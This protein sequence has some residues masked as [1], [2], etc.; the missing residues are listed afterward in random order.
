MSPSST[1][2]RPSSGSITLESASMT[3][4]SLGE[5]ASGGGAASLSVTSGQSSQ[6]RLERLGALQDAADVRP[7]RPESWRRLQR[8]MPN[9]HRPYGNVQRSP[10]LVRTRQ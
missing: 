1:K 6:G 10:N 9:T 2:S 4:D 5:G 3:S 7:R 8:K